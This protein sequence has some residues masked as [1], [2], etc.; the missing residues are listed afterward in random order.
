M[1]RSEAQ[2]QLEALAQAMRERRILDPRDYPIL[3]A[4]THKGLPLWRV[5]NLHLFDRNWPYEHAI[6]W[7]EHE[8][9]K[10]LILDGR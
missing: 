6:D 7:I 2:Q 8:A 10:S 4:P 1:N 3:G 5:N 9:I